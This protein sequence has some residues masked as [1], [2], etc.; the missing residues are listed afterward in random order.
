MKTALVTGASTGIGAAL[1]TTLLETGWRVY[2][3]ARSAARVEAIADADSRG[4]LIPISVDL[5]DIAAVTA[6]CDNLA[7]LT[8]RLDL[9]A[10]IAGVWHGTDEAYYGPLLPDLPTEQLLNV[11]NVGIMA[12]LLLAKSAARIMREA[13]RGQVLNLSGTFNSGGSGWIHYFTSKRALEQMTMALADEL[14]SSGVR[15]NCISPADTA[16]EAYVRFFPED[17]V[18]ALEPAEIARLALA[19]Q[20]APEFRHVSGQI[21]EIRSYTPSE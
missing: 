7:D 18:G 15:V 10:N 21:I 19:L 3:I 6:F 4:E 2:G 13:K 20:E 12:P 11:M 5:S 14:R 17:A 1:S 9:L 16:T 8:E